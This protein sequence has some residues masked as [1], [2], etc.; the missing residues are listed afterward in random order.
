MTGS[1]GMIIS[2]DRSRCSG[3]RCSGRPST[4]MYPLCAHSTAQQS[5]AEHS[6][7]EPR[8][9]LR[10]AHCAAIHSQCAGSL[11]ADLRLHQPEQGEREGALG[12]DTQA[13]GQV[14]VPR[15]MYATARGEWANNGPQPQLGLCVGYA[16]RPRGSR[17]V[18]RTDPNTAVRDYTGTGS[19]RTR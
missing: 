7:D 4:V 12:R 8:E 10:T 3:M 5:R 18:L 9:L 6:S 1:C 14:S 15:P 17:V 2:F 16:C 19:V 11:H 13:G